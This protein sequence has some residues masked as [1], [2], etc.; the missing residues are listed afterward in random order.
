MFLSSEVPCKMSSN[1]P[2]A[3]VFNGFVKLFFNVVT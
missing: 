1:L 3:E 2:S